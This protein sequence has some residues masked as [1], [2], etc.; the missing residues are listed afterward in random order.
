MIELKL[1]QKYPDKMS[2]IVRENILIYLTKLF[3][4]TLKVTVSYR[5]V[6][7][8]GLQIENTLL[9]KQIRVVNLVI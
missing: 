5:I 8:A 1:L 6:P 7:P 9:V 2:W 4:L 3:Y